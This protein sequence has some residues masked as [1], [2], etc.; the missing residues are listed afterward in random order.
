MPS[1]PHQHHLLIIQDD[2]GRRGYILSESTYSIGRD[3][4]CNILLVS[5]FVSRHHAILVRSLNEDG[6]Y[7]YRIIDGSH[8]GKPSSNGLLINGRKLKSHDLENN[9]EIIFGPQVYAIYYLLTGEAAFTPQLD[10]F[11]ITLISP[12]MIGEPEDESPPWKLLND[13]CLP[14]SLSP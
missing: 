2:Q 4:T 11:D 9:D 13:G 7:Q 12:N 1:E 10:E 3:P 8:D 14:R 5:H 6:L